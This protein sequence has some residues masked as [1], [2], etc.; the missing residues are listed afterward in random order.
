MQRGFLHH[1]PIAHVGDDRLFHQHSI[2][3]ARDLALAAGVLVECRGVGGRPARTVLPARLSSERA[4][5]ALALGKVWWRVCAG[6][7]AAMPRPQGGRRG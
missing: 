7:F 3:S 5:V 1:L 6:R 2:G 4:A